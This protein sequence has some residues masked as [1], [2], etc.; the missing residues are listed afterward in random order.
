[1]RKIERRLSLNLH[2]GRVPETVLKT[3]AVPQSGRV[4]SNL[5]RNSKNSEPTCVGCCHKMG[6]WDSLTPCVPQFAIRTG[7]SECKLFNFHLQLHCSRRADEADSLGTLNPQPSNQP[8]TIGLLTSLR[9]NCYDPP[10]VGGYEDSEMSGLKA[11]AARSDKTVAWS[12]PVASSVVIDAFVAMLVGRDCPSF[13]LIQMFCYQH[14]GNSVLPL[15][16][17]SM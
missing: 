5:M 1:M 13:D 14:L 9:T 8:R 15:R 3:V 11:A 16:S 2:P 12:G 7:V 4:R 17:R 10:H 6:L